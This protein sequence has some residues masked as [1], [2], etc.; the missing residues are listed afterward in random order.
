MS[1]EDE[2]KD[3][4][5]E[6][7][8]TPGTIKSEVSLLLHTKEALKIFMGRK[9]N[10]AEGVHH[11]P[12]ISVYAKLLRVIW[13]ACLGGNPFA[14][15][16]IQKIEVVLAE[17]EADLKTFLADLEEQVAIPRLKISKSLSVNPIE[18]KL[19]FATPY[20]YKVVYCL[21][22]LD[23]IVAKLIT[24]RHMALISPVEFDRGLRDSRGA[25]NRVLNTI[26]GFKPID[27]TLNDARDRNEK[28]MEAV[29]LMG[30]L[31]ELIVKN[32]YTPE[33]FPTRNLKIAGFG[34]RRKS[35][36]EPPKNLNEN[37]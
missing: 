34:R 1:D 17:S 21:G 32:Q 15:Y 3:V 13:G 14:K 25:I 11:I 19:N 9:E 20:T 24:L 10:K 16:W 4:N 26:G 6:A 22:M 29:A 28:Y 33:F 18:V 5:I 2:I 37:D 12:G 7:F 23:E 31:P 27:V 30:E 8:E 36:D 35:G